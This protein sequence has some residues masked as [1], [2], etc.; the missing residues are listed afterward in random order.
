MRDVNLS[1][2]QRIGRSREHPH[3]ASQEPHHVGDGM[4]RARGTELGRALDRRQR[5]IGSREGVDVEPFDRDDPD[6]ELEPFAERPARE[7]RRAEPIGR[8]VDLD[9]SAREFEQAVEAAVT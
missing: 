3:L 9:A 5:K 1:W 8:D 6:V 4:V 7:P 2:S